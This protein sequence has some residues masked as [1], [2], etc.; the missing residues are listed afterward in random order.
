MRQ[1]IGLVI[2]FFMKNSMRDSEDIDYS[3]NNCE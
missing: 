1:K 2:C 3:E